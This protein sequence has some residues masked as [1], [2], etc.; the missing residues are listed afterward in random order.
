MAVVRW[1]RLK[2]TVVMLRR[3]ETIANIMLRMVG[4]I[5]MPNRFRR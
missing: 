4:S 1:R 5:G 3:D 2:M